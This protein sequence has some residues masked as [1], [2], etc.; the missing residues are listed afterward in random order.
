[1][2]TLM[3]INR[4]G[5]GLHLISVF[6]VACQVDSEV[7]FTLTGASDLAS[8]FFTLRVFLDSISILFV[9]AI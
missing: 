6:L 2:T 9:Y 7:I 3:I 4:P 8:S 1:M 5:L